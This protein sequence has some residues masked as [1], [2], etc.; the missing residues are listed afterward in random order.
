MDSLG[1]P[2]KR[3]KSIQEPLGRLRSILVG[4]TAKF[5]LNNVFC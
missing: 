2:P 4:R 5:L 1:R 3:C